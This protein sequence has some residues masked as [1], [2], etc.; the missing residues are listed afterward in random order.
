MTIKEVEKL[1]G[2]TTKSIRDYEQ[3]GLIKITRNKDNDYRNYTLEDIN[4]LKF[5]KVLRYIDFSVEEISKI[6][7]DEQQL[8]IFLEDKSKKLELKSDEYLSKQN[9]CESLIKECKKDNF[10]NVINDYSETI[11]FLE[12][13]EGDHF[14]KNIREIFCPNLSAVIVQSLVFLGPILWLFIHIAQKQW[15]TMLLN[16]S[17]ALISTVF[18]VLE[19]V[20]YFSFRN[21]RKKLMKEKNKNNLLL[22][23][24][25]IIT[26]ILTLL[27]FILIN[28][29]VEHVLA[30]T[31]FL[32]YE[33]P[34]II[35]NMLIIA[36]VFFVII[37][38]GI[39]LKYFNI[40]KTE[41]LNI[42]I[43]MWN[44]YKVLTIII[45]ITILYCFITN[46]TFVTESEIIYHSSLHPFG[47][48]YKYSDVSKI[49]T[50]F[51]NKN[52]SLIEYKRKGEFYYTIYVDN[53]KITFSVPYTNEEIKR[54]EEH[55]YLE[56]EEFD[57][58]LVK[59][60]I[61]KESSLENSK[62][63]SLDEEYCD[64]F[65]KIINNLSD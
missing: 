51:G 2:L 33:I 16:S 4:K 60:D 29:I 9:I 31:N 65:K 6:L 41:S 40:N 26:L 63:C 37:V 59:L 18:L 52:F 62:Y 47:I 58:N 45:F 3:K 56:L 24:I 64:R 12:S 36:I 30:P 5:I 32:F 28:V 1:T 44:K 7:K 55:T 8:N 38:L 23:P 57:E 48:S 46:I 20:N 49:K 11:E 10:I 14:V 25:L 53:K 43:D 35:C 39:I 13:E 50:G 19:W 21:K 54:Y 22:F 34:P 27:F 61:P 17:L 15:D 42:Y